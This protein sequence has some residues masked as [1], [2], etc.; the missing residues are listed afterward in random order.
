MGS[1]KLTWFAVL[2]PTGKIKTFDEFLTTVLFVL[3]IFLCLNETIVKRCFIIYILH[4]HRGKTRSYEECTRVFF[5]YINLYNT[6]K[7]ILH[8]TWC[9]MKNKLLGVV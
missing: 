9:H 6:H 4:I 8:L 7:F 1:M 5:N 3:F 2:P